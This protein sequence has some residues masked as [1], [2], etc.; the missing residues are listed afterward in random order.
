MPYCYRRSQPPAPSAASM[1]WWRNA[2]VEADIAPDQTA[3]GNGDRSRAVLMAGSFPQNLRRAICFCHA[4]YFYPNRHSSLVRDRQL[5]RNRSEKYSLRY[6]RNHS[7][8][9]RQ[10]QNLRGKVDSIGYGVL[11]R[12]PCWAACRK[13]LVLLTGSRCP[14]FSGQNHGR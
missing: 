7:P 4:P 6:T 12:R 8:D 1:R 14:A 3:S 5:P 2:A 11:I 9:E 10:R 13:C